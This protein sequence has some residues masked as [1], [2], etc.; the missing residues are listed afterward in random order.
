VS[1]TANN[2]ERYDP[3]DCD[4]AYRACIL[5][6]EK[7][8]EEFSSDNLR[9]LAGEGGTTKQAPNQSW[10][11]SLIEA[12]KELWGPGELVRTPAQ[13][14]LIVARF[15]KAEGSWGHDDDAPEQLCRE[16]TGTQHRKTSRVWQVWFSALES[17]RLTPRSR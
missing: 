14:A 12:W 4:T 3:V 2:G 16:L 5:F 8:A 17:S 1:K 10:D 7:L 11:P 9:M 13:S 15:I 6:V